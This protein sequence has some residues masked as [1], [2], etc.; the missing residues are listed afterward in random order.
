MGNVELLNKKR[1]SFLSSGN[2]SSLSVLPTL[3]WAAETAKRDDV[4][5]V[6][7][8]TSEMER[9]V[10]DFLLK[11]RCGIVCVL[12]HGMYKFPIEP[13]M[14][15][16]LDERVLF[17]TLEKGS[18]KRA[19]RETCFRRNKAVTYIC[20]ELVFSSVGPTSSLYTL[21]E[22]DKPVTMF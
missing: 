12:A 21:T 8:F 18:L 17:L 9:Q 19:S 16:F 11:G 14:K 6:S 10:L 2:V 4:S 22:T 13:Y 20:E 5:V 15:A 3:D 1:I 7:G